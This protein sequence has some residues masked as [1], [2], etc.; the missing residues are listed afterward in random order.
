MEDGEGFQNYLRVS[1]L[2]REGNQ[3]L[4]QF[5]RSQYKEKMKVD[6]EDKPE[7]AQQFISS[8]GQELYESSFKLHQKKVFESGNAEKW[9]I[10]LL[11]TVIKTIDKN[12]DGNHNFITSKVKRN[13]KNL[14]E[15]RNQYEHL[16]RQSLTKDQFTNLWK[17]A[18]DS[19]VVLGGDEEEIDRIRT[20]ENIQGIKFQGS[21]S[22][23]QENTEK[24]R[25]LKEEGNSALKEN[26]FDLAIRKYSEA[27]NLVDICDEERVE[28]R[29]GSYL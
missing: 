15:F 6:W 2:L 11:S 13:I 24:A 8:I 7:F 20:A 18:R 12:M 17:L 23:N 4:R 28:S 14:V 1:L 5:F 21:G 9:D 29:E 16:P 26:K 3:I 27:L 19:L 10:A 25:K 22:V